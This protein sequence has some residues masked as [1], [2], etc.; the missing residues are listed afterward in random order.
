MPELVTGFWLVLLFLKYIVDNNWHRCFLE[1]EH[2]LSTDPNLRT[3]ERLP[4]HGEV[5]G[6]APWLRTR[7]KIIFL[8]S[9]TSLT[10]LF[11]PLHHQIPTHLQGCSLV[12]EADDKSKKLLWH[13]FRDS[14]FST[15]VE[16][17]GPRNRKICHELNV[18]RLKWF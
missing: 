2:G 17:S 6:G 11:K 14:L 9:L 4:E 12:C 18:F 16:F 3:L 15:T 10:L 7:S 5:P 1:A 13:H 8:Q